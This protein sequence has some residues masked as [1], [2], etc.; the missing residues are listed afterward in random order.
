[1]S[2][3]SKQKRRLDSFLKHGVTTVEGKSGY[4]LDIETELKQ[5]RV[6]KRLQVEHPIDIVPTFMGAHAVPTDYKGREETTSILLLMKCF[7]L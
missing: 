6:M 7:L 2:W 3:L 5:F 1:M 4:G